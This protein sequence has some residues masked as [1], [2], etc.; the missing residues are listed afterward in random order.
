MEDQLRALE[1]RIAALEK[2]LEHFSFDEAKAVHITGSPIGDVKVGDAANLVFNSSPVGAVINTDMD[3][4]EDRIDELE[5][6]LSDMMDELDDAESR[7]ED[8][9]EAIE[10]LV[11][12]LEE[13]HEL[14]D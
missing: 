3:E 2:Q 12:H 5:S 14:E 8:A 1:E 10:E 13:L 9:E 4:A 11:E 6:R 7:I